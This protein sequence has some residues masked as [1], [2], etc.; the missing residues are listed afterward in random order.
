MSRGERF[1]DPRW[2]AEGA[3]AGQ[4]TATSLNAARVVTHMAAYRNLCDTHAATSWHAVAWLTGTQQDICFAL[5]GTSELDC[6]LGAAATA[7]GG[8]SR[9]CWRN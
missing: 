4:N 1:A 2:G 6:P 5:A 8:R 7:A 9:P 3:L